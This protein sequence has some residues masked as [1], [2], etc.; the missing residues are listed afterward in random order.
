MNDAVG[1]RQE[2]LQLAAPRA[3]GDAGVTP[4][5]YLR[6]RP[7]GYGD[8][9][10]RRWPLVL[11]LHGAG[12]RGSALNAI[13][14]HGIPR[15]VEEGP[16]E[17]FPFLAVSPQCPRGSWWTDEL[18]ALDELLRHTQA[19]ERVDPD[20]VLVTGMSM[21][22][23]GTWALAITHPERF[24]AIAPVC[25]GGSAPGAPRIA[26][27]PIWAF[28]GGR[29]DVVPLSASE[30]MVEA[31]R[32]AGGAPRF[33]VYPELAHDSWT[34]AYGDPELY[35]WLLAQRRAVRQDPRP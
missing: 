23:Y 29:D 7:R 8:D 18:P 33:T 12:E 24:A 9:P 11:F 2:P 16:P 35:T 27:L 26:H 21:G 5:R 19:T 1:P 31:L 17:R 30:A 28:H 15:V 34:R 6:F 4:L 3:R 20:R 25:G 13:K 32:R 10:Q 14:R 22:G